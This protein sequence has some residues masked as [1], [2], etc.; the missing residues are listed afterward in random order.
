[1]SGRRGLA[2]NRRDPGAALTPRLLHLRLALPPPFPSPGRL[3]LPSRPA[4]RISV[5]PAAAGLRGRGR[6]AGPRGGRPRRGCR[7]GSPPHRGKVRPGAGRQQE[8]KAAVEVRTGEM[9]APQSPP[10]PRPL[11]VP[12]TGCIASSTQE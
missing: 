1:M 8:P 9:V 7:S 12:H 3:C 2:R 10:T 4:A 6:S 11:P 5:T